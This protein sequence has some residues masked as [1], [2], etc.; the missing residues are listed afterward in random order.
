MN[1]KEEHVNCESNEMVKP[2][3]VK[4]VSHMSKPELIKLFREKEVQF[5]S[6][7]SSRE[8]FINERIKLFQSVVKLEKKNIALEKKINSLSSIFSATLNN[9]AEL[10]RLGE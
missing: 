4:K 5:N 2:A 10:L 6:L 7:Y 3:R 1:T 9:T 8:E